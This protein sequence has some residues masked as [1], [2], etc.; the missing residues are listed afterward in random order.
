MVDG[1]PGDSATWCRS[2]YISNKFDL[3][4]SGSYLM[5]LLAYS[6][7]GD[8]I[9]AYNGSG[10]VKTISSAVYHSNI[11]MLE[12][13]QTYPNYLKRNSLHILNAIFQYFIVFLIFSLE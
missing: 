11:N 12:M 2:T 13:C 3:T 8:Y 7:D 1:K 4:V 6:Y 10:F 9:V 5:N